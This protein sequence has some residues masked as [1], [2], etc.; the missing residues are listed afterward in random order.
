MIRIT[1]L[2]NPLVR[3]LGETLYQFERPFVSDASKFQR[4][5]G[6]F[7]PTPHREAVKRA[8]EWFRRRD[9]A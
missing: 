5:F 7:D 9:A 4:A 3:E 8:V 2:F 6:P 1:G